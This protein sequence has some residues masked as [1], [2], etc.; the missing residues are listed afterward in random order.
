MGSASMGLTLSF[1]SPTIDEISDEF[2]FTDIESVLFNVCGPICAIFGA[3]FINLFIPMIGRRMAALA[4]GIVAFVGYIVLGSVNTLWLVFLFRCIVGMTVGLFSTTCPTLICELAPLEK[5]GLYGY[6]NQLLSAI[7]FML[8]TI[9][10]FGK[11]WRLNSY[12]CSIPS[13]LLILFIL[14]VP[15]PESSSVSDPFFHVFKYPME[16]IVSCILMF[17][18][19]FSGVQAI[20]SNLQPI[21]KETN[22]GVDSSIIA[23]VAN[24]A[25]VLTTAIASVVVD[26]W[27]RRL[28]W[29]ISAIGQFV[30]FILLMIYSLTKTHYALFL[31]GLFAEQLFYGIGTGP[32]PFLRAAEL[33]NDQVRASAMAFNTAVNWLITAIVVFIWPFMKNGMGLSYSYLFYALIQVLSIIFGVYAF[34]KQ[35]DLA[36][37]S[38]RIRIDESGESYKKTQIDDL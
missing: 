13:G 26:K 3:I 6:I 31:V 29:L 32:I 10:G 17:F 35:R 8:P 28:C 30:A 23:T 7:G 21:I 37:S 36:K 9:F 38:D 34:P 5:R 16:L 15:E 18:L 33:F 12:L 1:A 27:G 4:S 22:L 2:S 19:Q 14:F 20:I 25:Q 11:D 24:F